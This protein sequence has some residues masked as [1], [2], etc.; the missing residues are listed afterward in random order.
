MKLEDLVKGFEAAGLGEKEARAYVALA[1]LGTSGAAQV[2]EA[3]D[4]KRPD[5]YRVLEDLQARGLVDAT[6]ERPKRFTAVPGDRAVAVLRGEREAALAAVDR[7]KDSL[8]AGLAKVGKPV[9]EGGDLRFKI[10]QDERQL[11]GQAAR[12]VDGAKKEVLYAASS[13]GLRLLEE[14]DVRA[15]LDRARSRG[16]RVRV[17]ADVEAAN[18]D[19]AEGLAKV[20]DVR[21]APVPR[22]LRFLVVDDGLLAFVTADPLPASGAKET[23]LWLGASD[24]VNSERTHFAALWKEGVP[25]AE[26]VEELAT[27]RAPE[28]ADIVRGRV[29]RVEKLK[30][31]AFR[32]AKTFDLALDDEVPSALA[33]VLTDRAKD[34]LKVRL[35]LPPKAAAPK[36][37]DARPWP[38]APPAP[39]AVVDGRE[40]LLVLGTSTKGRK[41]DTSDPGER[42]VWSGLGAAAKGFADAF[43]AMWTH[44]G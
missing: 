21:H 35:L 8:L 29:Y 18:R 38:E 13:R 14:D 23:A 5:A 39:F 37:C 3:A 44:A 32:A 41:A 30:E 2:A 4:L 1:R 11:V 31:M 16:V 17:V 7:Q 33:R 26:R 19:V 43:Q 36:G 42:A 25:L 34:G 22:G 40:L 12:A 28:G 20:A 6:V 27:G 10:L 15:A 24:L 9:E